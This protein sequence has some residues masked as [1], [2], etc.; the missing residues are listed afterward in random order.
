VQCFGITQHPESGDYAIMLTHTGETLSS[1]IKNNKPL[2]FKTKVG[3]LNCIASG[4]A[5][6][7][8]HELKLVHRDFHD[9][10]ILI[11]NHQYGIYPYIIDLGLCR[12]EDEKDWGKYESPEYL[13]PEFFL[14]GQYRRPADVYALGIIVY[15]LFT[16]EFP[17]KESYEGWEEIEERVICDRWLEFQENTNLPPL[18]MELIK[19]C[20]D[21]NPLN[22]PKAKDL[23]ITTEV[24]AKDIGFY[25]EEYVNKT[26]EFYRQYEEMERKRK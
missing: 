24:W 16:G 26:S 6:I 3:L 1:Y 7:H 2:N 10:N 4:L 23:E 11:A 5:S 15:F 14:S 25:G 18:I 21:R 9:C 8:E 13:P 20:C 12:K 22:R 17:F 19:D